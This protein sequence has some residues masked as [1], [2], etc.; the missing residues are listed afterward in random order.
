VSDPLAHWE[1]EPLRVWE[2][3]WGVPEVEA[4]ERLGSTNDRAR[5]RAEAGAPPWTVVIADEQTRGRGRAGRTWSSPAG[6]GL[7]LSFLAPHPAARAPLAPV[8]VGLA[9]ARAVARVCGLEALVKWPNDLWLGD[10]KVAGILCEA[11]AGALVVGVG[12]NV[13]QRP[14]DFP[15]EIRGRATSL[16]AAAGRSVS[17]A[18]LAGELLRGA[19]ALLDGAAPRLDGELGLELERRD[20]LRGRALR[21]GDVRG[22][23]AGVDP[24]GRLRV[25][26]ADGSIRAVVAGHVELAADRGEERACN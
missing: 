7:W 5:E 1:A 23:G 25:L 14:E 13:R 16:E 21:I 6:R 10:R 9:L 4:W 20:L 19:R 11:A 15:D 12:V 22:K 18:L 17:R 26:T 8:L 3:L 24:Q 2:G